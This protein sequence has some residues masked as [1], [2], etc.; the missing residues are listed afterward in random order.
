[1]INDETEFCD[2]DVLQ[3]VL[4]GKVTVKIEQVFEGKYFSR[5]KEIIS[6]Q[7]LL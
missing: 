5:I 2:P 7:S 3:A 6:G 1:M 4:D